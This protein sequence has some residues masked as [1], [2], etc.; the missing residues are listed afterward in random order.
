M[1]L[2]YFLPSLLTYLPTPRSTVLLERLDGSQ[3]VKN[4]PTFYWNRMFI[5]TFTS[6]RHLSL[7]WVISIQGM[8]LHPTSLKSILITLSHLRLV[9]LSGTIP[10]V[11]PTET[12]YKSLQSTYKL[13]ASQNVFFSILLPE[14]YGWRMHFIRHLIMYLF[15]NHMLSHSS[16]DNIFSKSSLITKSTLETF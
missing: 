16:K 5:S 8:P 14:I 3:L 10:S 2:I 1:S 15:F 6:A 4:F 11:F 13:H 7:T 12:L 9:L